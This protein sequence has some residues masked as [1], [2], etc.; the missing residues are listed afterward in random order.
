MR[1]IFV[2]FLLSLA[3]VATAR[4]ADSDRHWTTN[5]VHKGIIS[6]TE[7][8]SRF[9]PNGFVGSFTVS[10]MLETLMQEPVEDTIFNWKWP[11]GYAWDS[12]EVGNAT[13]DGKT[14][15]VRVS[16]LQKY[17]DL[18]EAFRGMK[19]LSIELNL[20]V[21]FLGQNRVMNQGFHITGADNTHLQW[22]RIS[23]GSK[24][25]KPI[26]IG[27]AGEK[28]DSIVPGSP[29]WEDWFQLNFDR[30][31]DDYSSDP[32]ARARWNKETYRKAER[33][34][35]TFDYPAVK[36]IQWMGLVSWETL[37]RKYGERESRSS[38]PIR[39]PKPPMPPPNPSW[40]PSQTHLNRR[41]GKPTLRPIPL[42]K[43]TTNQVLPPTHLK[44]P[45][46]A[47][48]AASPKTPLKKTPA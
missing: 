31:Q 35:L 41:R 30:R 9:D 22:E 16:D 8:G 29:K 21:E 40:L 27:Q 48:S 13:V 10:Y 38:R 2:L 7:N 37:L 14:V 42:S 25:I 18:L 47:T 4:A 34:E 46:P 23:Y 32:K 19:P 33:V 5:G 45:T 28:T 44:R 1:P 12:L 36:S 39:W 17:P 6:H 43:P 15:A 3:L 11:E 20:H 24:T 26:V